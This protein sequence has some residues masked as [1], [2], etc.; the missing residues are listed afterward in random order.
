MWTENWQE[1]EVIRLFDW[2]TKL[3][4]TRWGQICAVIN[5]T[6][7]RKQKEDQTHIATDIMVL[8]TP[9][10]RNSCQWHDHI[11]DY[12][13]LSYE[14]QS[15]RKSS[16]NQNHSD[17]SDTLKERFILN[18]NQFYFLNEIQSIDIIFLV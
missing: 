11:N 6:R 10:H 18:V 4:N 7:R 15:N 1:T 9:L 5:R 16:Y 17:C 13:W 2:E 8:T 3:F 14:S 12:Y